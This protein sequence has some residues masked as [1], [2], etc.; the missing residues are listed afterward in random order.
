MLLLYLSAY[1]LINIEVKVKTI[2]TSEVIIIKK[3][4]SETI[5]LPAFH[6]K[7][8][9]SVFDITNSPT[10]G[11]LGDI[12]GETVPP[13]GSCILL[14]KLPAK[15]IGVVSQK[16]HFTPPVSADETNIEAFMEDTYN[17]LNEMTTTDFSLGK[18]AAYCDK[19]GSLFPN[20]KSFTI[21]SLFVAINNLKII[22]DILS[23]A[24]DIHEFCRN[25]ASAMITE[26]EYTQQ[27]VMRFAIFWRKSTTEKLNLSSGSY[28]FPG[29]L[30]VSYR[31]RTLNISS[32]LPRL[33]IHCNIN[34]D[35]LLNTGTENEKI[36]WIKQQI[37][38]NITNVIAESNPRP[39][40]KI[41][42]NKPTISM[43]INDRLMYF[44]FALL[45]KNEDFNICPHCKKLLTNGNLYCNRKHM[46]SFQKSSPTGKMSSMVNK[47]L[48]RG[49]L[50]T[51]Q[52]DE[53]TNYGK[54]LLNEYPYEKVK[55]ILQSKKEEYSK[56]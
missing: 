36:D 24:I 28:P 7:T 10:K 39:S 19:Y 4:Y 37:I 30:L 29:F 14:D 44:L 35:A 6:P 13:H 3:I 11:L 46:E 40:V 22:L 41:K 43:I 38:S 18:Y 52:C 21:I 56:I 45:T 2:K 50:T 54:K 16:S 51:I 12:C 20:N 1:R 53:L 25:I 48:Q 31:N 33:I 32:L 55:K 34:D 49:H 17:L 9:V 47:W 26:F 15:F 42:N 5:F 27:S 8:C 23:S